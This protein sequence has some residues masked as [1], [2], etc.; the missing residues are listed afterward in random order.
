MFHTDLLAFS[1]SIV[2]PHLFVGKQTFVG[3]LKDDVCFNW[4]NENIS[5]IFLLIVQRLH[6]SQQI[7]P[8]FIVEATESTN[9][10][11]LLVL[12]PFLLASFSSWFPDTRDENVHDFFNYLSNDDH[13]G[14]L[15]LHGCFFITEDN[16]GGCPFT[17]NQFLFFSILA[18]LN[19]T[20]QPLWRNSKHFLNVVRLC[21]LCCTDETTRYIAD[22]RERLKLALQRA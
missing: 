18:W 22:R 7:F 6:V 21:L 9:S 5:F 11:Y 3:H 16:N 8:V 17:K 15:I 20:N 19:S 12:F 14:L 13:S 4:I 10:G 1:S 2:T